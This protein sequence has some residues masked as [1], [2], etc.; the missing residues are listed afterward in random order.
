MRAGDE[1]ELTVEKMVHGGRGLCRSEQ[2]VV[3]VEAVLP[4]EKV[5]VKITTA[6]KDFAEG[7][8]VSVLEPSPKRVE[9]PCPWAYNCGGCQYQ[10]TSIENQ[11]VLKLEVLKNTLQRVGKIDPQLVRE[12]VPS[13]RATHYRNTVQFRGDGKKMGFFRRGSRD[14]VDVESCLI[15]DHR[16][17][18]VYHRLK[19]EPFRTLIIRT[20]GE[21]VIVMGDAEEEI[22]LDPA[23]LGVDGITVAV[24]GVTKYS[25]GDLWLEHRLNGKARESESERLF[26]VSA[27]SFYQVNPRVLE[28]LADHLDVKL[29]IKRGELWD[30][31]GGVGVFGIL[32]A[33]RFERVRSFE[34]SRS[35]RADLEINL[36][37]NDVKNVENVAWD[38]ELGLGEHEQAPDTVILDPPRQGITKKLARDLAFLRP[39]QIFYVSCE[40][41]TLARDLRILLDSG[42]FRLADITPFEMFPQTYHLECCAHLVRKDEG[43]LSQ[44]GD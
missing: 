4:G 5:K 44:G 35:A 39:A 29:S 7:R 13:P 37:L 15:A 11:R 32:F 6:K 34:I 22:E 14:V 23:L 26:H 3:F 21:R 41:A 38:G 42:F 19:D 31:F 16:I 17:N 9:A 30:L 8:A 27:G 33:D 20:D 24:N 12:M 36:R 25:E 18:S 28:R 43:P 40:P 10:H 1:I 2:G